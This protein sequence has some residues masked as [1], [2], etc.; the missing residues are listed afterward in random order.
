[1]PAKFTASTYN[2]SSDYTGGY[3]L[4]A[5]SHARRF[6]GSKAGWTRAD[7]AENTCTVGSG[8]P[9][10]MNGR[11]VADDDSERG[12]VCGDG[13]SDEGILRTEEFKGGIMRTV[14]VDVRVSKETGKTP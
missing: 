3:A 9:G 4:S 11:E 6:S 5:M 8:R 14:D 1:M 13:A 12:P 2:Y 7:D 10:G